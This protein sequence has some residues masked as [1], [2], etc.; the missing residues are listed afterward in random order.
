MNVNHPTKLEL[1]IG[2]MGDHTSVVL[3]EEGTILYERLGPGFVPQDCAE[4][5]PTDEEWSAF[6]SELERLGVWNW[7][8][9]YFNS[10]VCDGTQWGVKVNHAGRNIKVSGSNSYPKADGKPNRSTSPTECF[11]MFSAAVSRLAGGREFR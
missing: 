9:D 5:R 11:N 4:V 8:R 10:N 3:K 2:G 6:W 7:R 1:S